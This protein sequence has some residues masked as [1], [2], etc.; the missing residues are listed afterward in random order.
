MPVFVRLAFCFWNNMAN[1]TKFNYAVGRPWNIR[2]PNGAVS[3]YMTYNNEVFYGTTADAHSL[4]EYCNGKLDEDE[5]KR[6]PY[7]I[8]KL[9]EIPEYK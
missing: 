3:T 4:V 9:V 2:E 6:N 1:T 8:Y 5:R 7:K